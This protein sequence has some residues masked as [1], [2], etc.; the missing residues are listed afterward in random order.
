[1]LPTFSFACLFHQPAKQDVLKG[2][3]PGYDQSS[4][5]VVQKPPELEEPRSIDSDKSE[6]HPVPQ[7]IPAAE[8]F[9]QE[10]VLFLNPV[11]HRQEYLGFRYSEGNACRDQ[12]EIKDLFHEVRFP[13]SILCRQH[14]LLQ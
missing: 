14:P 8:Q 7:A 10:G 5:E 4:Q 6:C 2:A 9:A 13:L 12:R 3:Q 11:P 1:M